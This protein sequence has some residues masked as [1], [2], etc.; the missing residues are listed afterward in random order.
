MNGNR[1]WSKA[2]PCAYAQRS[3]GGREVSLCATQLVTMPTLSPARHAPRRPPPRRAR[4]ERCT[5]HSPQALVSGT[6]DR[7][8][9]LTRRRRRLP[10]SFGG[11]HCAR[12]AVQ[13]AP[14]RRVLPAASSD[15][16]TV[17]PNVVLIPLASNHALSSPSRTRAPTHHDGNSAPHPTLAPHAIHQRNL[18]PVLA[19]P[20]P[21]DAAAAGLP[22]VPCAR[23]RSATSLSRPYAGRLRPCL[24]ARSYLSP[25]LSAAAAPRSSLR[26][27]RRVAR[28]SAGSR[29]CAAS[30]CG[31]VGARAQQRRQCER[32]LEPAYIAREAQ[33]P[34]TP[35]VA[36]ADRLSPQVDGR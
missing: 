25:T 16:R 14:F 9:R 4:A 34:R 20:P 11:M 17:C 3:V 5:A 13:P 15:A 27:A 36:A 33:R 7:L 19:A 18:A 32:V 26:R 12:A 2:P 31:A 29:P 1:P 35:H 21:A 10:R 22:A 28:E 6:P 8:L 30:D 24:S 23:S